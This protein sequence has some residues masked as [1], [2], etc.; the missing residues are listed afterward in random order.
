MNLAMLLIS[1][2]T[3]VQFNCENLFDFRHD[4]LK[5]DIEFTPE[6]KRRWTPR[7][8]RNKLDN[9][10]KVI[11][12]CG[13]EAGEWRLP[14]MVALCEVENDSVMN[15]L[16]RRSPLRNLGY[17]F[18]ITNSP[19]TRGIDVALLWHPGSF[20]MIRN[21]A[22]G[23][24]MNDGERPT[25]DILYACGRTASGDTLHVFVVHAPSRYGGNKL[26][27]PRRMAVTDRL[28][29]AVDSIRRQCAE[30]K[31]IISG[32]FNDYYDSPIFDKLNS[33]GL[34]NVSTNAIGDN[35]AKATYKYKG[36]WKSIDHI[37][38]SRNLTTRLRSCRINDLP[39]LLEDDLKYGG[40]KPFRT[41]NGYKYQN[42]YSD[43]L[44]LVMKL[45]QNKL[46]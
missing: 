43:H 26:T 32:D 24:R 46:K 10:T 9:I 21:Y 7:K 33:N 6:G 3:F 29:M 2:F 22:I 20:A 17:E 11:T 44:P 35:G 45:E 42:G 40:V 12:S 25:R 37:F 41:S 23:V 28:N 38:I 36:E 14:D 18:A 39:F 8:Y 4:C 1:V 27:R 34:I 5:E 31:I 13:M 19:D 30:P 15:D 16:T